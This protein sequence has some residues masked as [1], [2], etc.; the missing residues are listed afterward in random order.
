MSP[1]LPF[2]VLGIASGSVYGLAGVGL[3]LTYKT[4]GIFNFAHGALA[5][6]AAYVFYALHVQEGLPWGLAA[7]LSTLVLGPLLGIGFESFAN[8]L[9][10]T[11]LVWRIVATVGV[12]IS[13]E[14]LFT[15]LYGSTY[16]PYPQF[17][18]T[19]TFGVF[20]TRVTYEQ[21][22]TTIISVVATG[23]L[24]VFFRTARLGKAMRAVV[25]D[26]N[27]LDLAGTSPSRVRRLAW[28]IGCIFAAVSGILLAPSV[29]LSASALTLLVVQAFG[30]AAIGAFVSLPITWLGGVAIGI[31]SSL[32][33]GYV[34]STSI[35][36]GL[37][38]TLPFIVLFLVLL[39]FPR[40]RLESQPVA[41]LRRPLI[42][43]APARVHVGLAVPVL[44]FL[45]VVPHIVG[46]DLSS[47]T[48]TL[49]Y[50][51][52]FLS[53]SL[54][55]RTSGQ[56]SLCHMGFA[57]IGAVAFSKLAVEAGVPWLFAV[58]LAG[59]VAVPIGA[60][61]AIP[62]IRLSGLY[63][64]LAT[65]GFG[66]L[67]ANMFYTSNLMFGITDV[68]ISMPMPHLGWISLDSPTG[69]YYVVLAATALMALLVVALVRGRLGRVLR[70]M[71]DSPAALATSGTSTTVTRVLVFCISAYLAAVAGAF[72]GM[73]LQS[74]TG[75]SFDPFMSL[76]LMAVIMI[77]QGGEPWN[78]I[79]AGAGLGLIPTYITASSTSTYLQCFFGVGAVLAA[80]GLQG[81][82]PAK[83]RSFL[84]RIGG[85][86]PL[87][88]LAP[89]GAVFLSAPSAL[90]AVA[91]PDRAPA[92]ALSSSDPQPVPG[93]RAPFTLAVRDLT[94]RFGGLV[95][96]DG[97]NLE[98]GPGS[99]TGLIGPNGAG[100]TTVFNAC[101]GL[102]RPAGGRIL[103]DDVDVSGQGPAARARRGLGRSFQQ[104]ELFDSLSVADNVAMGREASLAGASVH[105]HLVS[106]ASQRRTVQAAVAEAL[107]LC[108]IESLAGLQAGALSTGQRRLVELARC[109]AGPF[110]FL[111]LDEPSSGLDRNET[112]QF[113]AI[114]RQ[115]VA[116]RGVGI[117][118]VEHDMALVMEVCQKIFVMDFGVLIY[119]GTPGE[120]S[121]SEVVRAAYLGSQDVEIAQPETGA[122][123]PL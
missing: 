65:F 71:A 53:L 31:A 112:S 74:V 106:P 103:F 82:M 44:A 6:V 62:A 35:W 17:L 26:P 95:A 10:R 5:T 36:G 69:F 115:V 85:R 83:L 2:I 45:I 75:Q 39:V 86:S 42:W 58:L 34:S 14:A 108:G 33:T 79:I 111:L 51:M 80:L 13:V 18:S 49:T 29:S 64:A 57:A 109:L 121:A 93:H 11:A 22:I 78:A 84:E 37:P 91:R 59:L 87:P 114:I 47:W 63:L 27:L 3:V 90:S 66:L 96:V 100:K 12:L 61:L 20:G 72:M 107:T 77:V 98:A 81:G 120:V 1:I 28:I 123:S 32:I 105:G 54:L 117:L 24:Y 97:L 9:S 94:V 92:V 119:S 113:G 19:S 46:F 102:V 70:A 88:V 68:G 101:T 25:D 40:R 7:L 4:S 56:P 76:T 67:L 118:L 43:R 30:A 73:V 99:I 15:L 23:G 104:M 55:V 48:T 21:L 38:A 16:R 41:M 110:G 8:G 116:E 89:A 122:R 60:L 50:V 52:L